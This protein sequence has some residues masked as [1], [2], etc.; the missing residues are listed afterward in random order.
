MAINEPQP[1]GPALRLL[2]KISRNTPY[3]RGK[4][5]LQEWL[6]H[7]C[8]KQSG[9]CEVA[10]LNRQLE[11]RCHLSDEVQYAIWMGGEQYER[12]PKRYFKS[13][14]R[15]GMVVLD[16][17][18]N[19]GFHSLLASRA[20]GAGGQVHAFEPVR[21][22]FEDLQWNLERNRAANVTANRLIV[23]DSPGEKVI[24]LGEPGNSGSAS[25]AFAP[26]H[27]SEQET[28]MA[29]TLDAYAE[30]KALPRVDIIKID[31]EGHEM[32]VLNGAPHT[33]H[34]RPILLLEVMHHLP[35]RAGSS[36][37]ELFSATAGLGYAPHAIHLDGHTTPLTAPQ[38]GQIIAFLPRDGGEHS[39][40]R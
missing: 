16:I 10:P 36:S 9:Y 1:V 12:G 38:D 37:A 26:E 3:F 29:T 11:M 15:N 30:A 8:F 18:A 7:R 14:L 4:W 25:M 17:G 28:V 19:V 39:P 20:V 32:A 27:E 6:F 40:A 21:R 13:R 23:L 5:R 35:K 24:Y 33:L 31:V 34:T 2:G 22:Q